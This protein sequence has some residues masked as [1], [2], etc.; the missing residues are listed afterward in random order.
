MIRWSSVLHF[1]EPSS[2]AAPAQSCNLRTLHGVFM[3]LFVAW[4]HAPKVYAQDRLPLKLIQTIPM[5]NVKGRMDHLGINVKGKRLFAAALD[6]NTLEIIDLKAGKRIFSI[7]AQSKPQGVFYSPDFNRVFVANGT[8]GTCKIYSGE[9]FTLIDSLSLGTNPSHVGYDPA[10]K[11]LYVGIGVPTSE[12]GALAVVDTRSNKHIGD[13]RTE[14]R[15]GGVKIE[16]SG[17]RIFVTLRGIPKVGVLDRTKREQITTW[18]FTGATFISA[19]A[20][21]ETDHRLFGGTRSPPMLIVFDTESGK[22]I[23][24][25]EGV[26]GVDD[27]WYDAVH[28]R[29]YASGGRDVDVGFVFVYQQEDAD[30]YELISKVPTRP[31][32][33][34]SIWVPELNRYYVSAAANDKDDAAILVF[35]PQP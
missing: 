18:P 17:P 29:I 11:Y 32:S 22:Q 33:Q 26:A 1:L 24:Q 4:N 20:F 28:K 13:I 34:T 14:V 8:D 19:L 3:A 2:N 12:P 5:P 21:D 31:N 6:N 35:E 7:P 15:P 30:H 25:L 10:T 9:K 27:L 23:T 16:K